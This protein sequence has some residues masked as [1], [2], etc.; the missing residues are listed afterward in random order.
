ML[1]NKGDLQQLITYSLWTTPRN[2]KRLYCLWVSDP[3]QELHGRYSSPGAGVHLTTHSF[4]ERLLPV[5]QREAILNNE[6]IKPKPLYWL[7]GFVLVFLVLFWVE[8]SGIKTKADLHTVVLQKQ[9]MCSLCTRT[10]RFSAREL[11]DK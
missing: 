6:C 3:N 5:T 7:M 8:R 9:G 10:A 11:N 4:P 1:C 2:D